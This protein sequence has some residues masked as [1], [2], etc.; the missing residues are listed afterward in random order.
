MKPS[1]LNNSHN[2]LKPVFDRYL[3]E[4]DGTAKPTQLLRQ[5]KYQHA[6]NNIL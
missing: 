3:L 5:N 1:P 6:V 2:E 4:N